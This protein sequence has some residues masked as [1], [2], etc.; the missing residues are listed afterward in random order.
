MKAS[1]IVQVCA[2][3]EC[4]PSWLLGVQEEGQHLPPESELLKALKRE[5]AKLNNRGQQKAVDNTRD[6]TYVPE[7]RKRADS[8]ALDAESGERRPA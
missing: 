8:E 2:V 5:F 7:Y 4:S 3:L 6:L 1:M